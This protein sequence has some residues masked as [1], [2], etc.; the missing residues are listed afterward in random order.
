MTLSEKKLKQKVLGG[1]MA[2]VLEHLPRKCK[3]LS[4]SPN[5]AEREREREREIKAL[6]GG[7]RLSGFKSWLSRISPGQFTQSLSISFLQFFWQHWDLN[8][9]LH[10]C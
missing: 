2:Q 3:I 7:L 5:N 4:L 6:M 9:G 1:G 10:A 8:S